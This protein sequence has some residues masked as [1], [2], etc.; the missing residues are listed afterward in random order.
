MLRALHL[1]V[2]TESWTWILD[3]MG[4]RPF[5][6]PNVGRL[7]VERRVALDN[8]LRKPGWDAVNT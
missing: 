3:E 5:Y 1:P 4:Q 8:T 6:P 2:D 7:A